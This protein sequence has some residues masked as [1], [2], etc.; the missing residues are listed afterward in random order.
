MKDFRPMFA[1][2]PNP[3]M[4]MSSSGHL[5]LEVCTFNVLGST[6]ASMLGS[7]KGIETGSD[8]YLWVQGLREGNGGGC[9]DQLLV[10]R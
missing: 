10:G 9:V 2:V 4:G 8:I 6:G 5:V 3:G 7:P 1:R